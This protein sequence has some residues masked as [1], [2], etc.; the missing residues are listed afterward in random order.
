MKKEVIEK[1]CRKA[2]MTP[3]RRTKID[4]I[5]V[6]IADG[7]SSQPHRSFAR[8]GVEE[9]EF[10]KGCYATLWW[11]SKDNDLDIGQP[12]F[13]DPMHNPEYDLRTKKMARINSAIQEASGFLSRRKEIRKNA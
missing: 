7:F 5:E 2:G 6:F 1:A 11:A 13:F 8:F 10:P 4:G 3:A 12:L 9:G